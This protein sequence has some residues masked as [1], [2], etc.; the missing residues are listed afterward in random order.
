LKALT[1]EFTPPGK[2]VFDFSYNSADFT[3]EISGLTVELTMGSSSDP[4]NIFFIDS[5][6]III[7][8]SN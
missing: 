7:V 5:N 4:E 1:G 6:I 3:L 8:V 2:K